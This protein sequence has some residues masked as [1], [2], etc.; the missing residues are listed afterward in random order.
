MNKEYE[1]S[2]LRYRE[3]YY[4]CLQY[5]KYKDKINEIET[6][7]GRSSYAQTGRS[8]SGHADPTAA[9]VIKAEKYREYCE[10]IEQT[11]I[12]VGGDYADIYQTIMT[13]VTIG[14]S[15]EQLRALGKIPKYK[16]GKYCGK[17]MFYNLRRKFYWLLDFKKK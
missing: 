14:L 12:E 11:A 9:K 6:G 17:N 4:F 3:L 8:G 2:N 7:G 5:Q 15:Y 16:D 13:N 10:L 1:I